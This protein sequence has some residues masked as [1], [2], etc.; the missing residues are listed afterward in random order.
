[1]SRARICAHM[2]NQ[3]GGLDEKAD[4]ESLAK[5]KEPPFADESPRVAAQTT[6]VLTPPPRRPSSSSPVVHV[7]NQPLWGLP[8]LLDACD[9]SRCPKGR[10]QPSSYLSNATPQVGEAHSHTTGSLWEHTPTTDRGLQLITWT[11]VPTSCPNIGVWLHHRDRA[12]KSAQKQTCVSF[13]SSQQ[14]KSKKGSFSKKYLWKMCLCLKK[15][16]L[17]WVQVHYRETHVP[18]EYGTH[19]QFYLKCL[20]EKPCP[21]VP[22]K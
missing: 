17:S 6:S 1:M 18:T 15:S 19:G 8:P 10:S 3:E 16:G 20:L 9:W 14:Q 13:K 7:V 22:Y 11:R 12:W 5:S 4:W 21:C 2:T